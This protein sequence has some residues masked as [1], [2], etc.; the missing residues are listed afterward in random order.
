MKFW[1]ID[2]MLLDGIQF[3]LMFWQF[4]H[5]DRNLIKDFGRVL[6]KDIKSH[7]ST[8]I[9]TQT[10]EAQHQYQLYQCLMNLLTEKVRLKI[11]K[12]SHKYSI[13]ELWS[14]SILYKFIVF[15]ASIDTRATLSHI[16]ENLASLDIYVD[17]VSDNAT[18]FNEY[19]T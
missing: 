18:K 13:G 1:W 11:V 5:R 8:Y 19:V 9:Q 17:K 4:Q 14:G 12:E 3:W 7:C 10:R 15:R 16:R 6:L 2:A